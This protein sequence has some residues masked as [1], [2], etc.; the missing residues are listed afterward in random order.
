M[1]K[2]NVFDD[3]NSSNKLELRINEAYNSLFI[4]IKVDEKVQDKNF[5]SAWMTVDYRDLEDLIKSIED[6]KKEIEV[7]M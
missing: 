1:S 6:L 5:K 2:K 4:K 3:I 7:N